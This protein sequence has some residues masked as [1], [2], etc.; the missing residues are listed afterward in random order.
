MYY[1]RIIDMKLGKFQRLQYRVKAI[2]NCFT[3]AYA[4]LTM[5]AYLHI[6][7]SLQILSVPDSLQ[8]S[9]LEAQDKVVYQEAR[10][11]KTLILWELVVEI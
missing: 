7:N 1:L 9:L 10:S 11:A 8:Y 6:W 5:Y 4:H 3:K 2:C